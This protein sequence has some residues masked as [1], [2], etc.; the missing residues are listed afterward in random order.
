MS[1][2]DS[3]CIARELKSLTVNVC[4]HAG[5]TDP[6]AFS[7]GCQ[8]G[9]ARSM[10]GSVEQPLPSNCFMKY[11]LR[12]SSNRPFRKFAMKINIWK[13]LTGTTRSVYGLISKESGWEAQM[14]RP[15]VVLFLSAG[16]FPCCTKL[17]LVTRF[18]SAFS[19]TALY[20]AD[21]LSVPK[22]GRE[23]ER[24]QASDGWSQPGSAL[25]FPN[26][27]RNASAEQGAPTPSLLS[28]N[29]TGQMLLKVRE[30]LQL[31]SRA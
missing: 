14:S 23:E 26:S 8:T 4:S 2:D 20:K 12:R 7:P 18:R 3:H 11:K 25:A 30:T 1:A 21:T 5:D 13:L 9:A 22:T 24:T 16:S 19:I 15:P 31:S 27:S 29:A 10:A 17:A 28:A 6:R